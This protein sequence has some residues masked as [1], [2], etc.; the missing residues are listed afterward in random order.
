MKGE[1][2]LKKG[3]E[4]ILLVMMTL[5]WWSIFY[6]ELCFSE[7]IFQPVQRE[8]R[9]AVLNRQEGKYIFRDSGEEVVVTSR[10]WEWITEQSGEQEKKE[11]P[12]EEKTEM[13]I[14]YD[15]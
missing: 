14:D 11:P 5:G 15:K 10:L 13:E 3:R 8:E 6:P 1:N 9:D 12:K 7:D 2:S 4:K